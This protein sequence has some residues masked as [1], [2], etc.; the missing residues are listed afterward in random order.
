MSDKY[1]IGLTIY[2]RA[3]YTIYLH[4]SNDFLLCEFININIDIC[5]SVQPK[6]NDF[7][8]VETHFNIRTHP[9]SYAGKYRAVN[10]DP[11]LGYIIQL[12]YSNLYLI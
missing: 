12:A 11:V 5:I 3:L 9:S 6:T 1:M 8:I 10:L 2:R 7:F 4:K